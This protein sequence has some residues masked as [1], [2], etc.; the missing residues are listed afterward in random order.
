[1]TQ[2]KKNGG[3]VESFDLAKLKISIK[4]ACDDAG[5][6]LSETEKLVKEVSALVED[7]V[8]G[9][10]IVNS[11]DIRNFILKRTDIVCKPVSGA[12]RKFEKRK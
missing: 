2:V 3:T 5:L 11:K 10:E 12:W 1:M 4:S 8:K 6:T 9:K 7:F